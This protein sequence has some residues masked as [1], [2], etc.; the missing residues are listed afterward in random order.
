MLRRA[1]LSPNIKDRLD[2]SCAVFDPAGEL[3]AQAAHIPV[4]LGSMAFAMRGIV[5]GQRW[6]P[7]D[8]LIVNDPFLGG[9]H[10]P[11]VTAVAPV[12]IDGAL[13]GFVAN[14]AHHAD[15]GA[16]TPGS[17]PVSTRLEDEGVVIAPTFVVRQGERDE[18][19]LDAIV[20]RTRDPVVA[21][22]DFAA[23]FSANRCGVLGLEALVAGTGVDGYLGR[24]RELDAYAER[25]ARS[26]L[27]SLPDGEYRFV[28]VMDDDG[29]GARDIPVEVALRVD[30]GEV[31]VDFTGTAPQVRGNINCPLS[32]TAAS[33]YY[34]FRCLMPDDV[35]A[36]A[37]SFRPLRL[38]APEGCLVNARRPAAVAAGNVET[39]MRIVDCLLGALSKAIPGRIPAASHGSMNN[40]AMGG[41]AGGR[42][43]D[44]YETLGGGMGAG[45]AGGGLS[46]IH[47]HMTNTR[48]TPIEGVELHYPLRIRRYAIRRGTGGAGRRPGGD[49]LVREYELLE[50]ATV[51]LLTERRMHRPWG[52][53]GGRSGASGENRRNGERLPPKVS[54]EA[55]AGDRVAVA[56]PGGGPQAPPEA[57]GVELAD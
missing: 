4:H 5:S 23:Q 26:G 33:V 55:V 46:A 30:R 32:V 24:L 28:D 36:S 39:S 10:L 13:V 29:A 51:T 44:Y 25:M 8:M 35:P 50:P 16:S 2:Y 7:G 27:A 42:A 37:G 45:P 18:G 11:D 54:F 34:V 52:L 1:S 19:A 22:G 53:E 31:A 47:S 14:R 15:I 20:R 12:F 17:M 9:T 38:H 3:C 49:G 57:G 6:A 56:T 43:W 40:I 41:V 48:N 21:R